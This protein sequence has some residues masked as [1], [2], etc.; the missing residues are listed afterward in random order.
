[1]ALA[2]LAV[3][4]T[5]KS[6]S[7]ARPVALG[8][9]GAIAVA[10]A[11]AG[12]VGMESDGR[13]R[14]A[15]YLATAYLVVLVA[16]LGVL[17]R[18]VPDA[19]FILFIAYPQVWSLVG[20]RLP[21][22][23]WTLLVLA[24]SLGGL[25]LHQVQARESVVQVIGGQLTGVAFSLLIG[26]WINVLFDRSRVQARLIEQL[27]RAKAE[28]TTLERER[29][30]QAE[31]ERL[32]RD[33]HDTLAQG[34]TSILMLART[35]MA[36]LATDPAAARER[37]ELVEEVAGENLAQA[38]ALVAAQS[39]V[40]LDGTSLRDALAQLAARFTR[41]TGIEV[42]LSLTG[43]A[44]DGDPPADGGQ[45]GLRPAEELVLLRAAQEA[46]TN[47]RR[48][49]SPRRVSL[50]LATT[51]PGEVTMR[52]VDDGV[53]FAV[54]AATGSGLTGLRRRVE[55]AG[56]ELVVTSTPG[57]GTQVVARVVSGQ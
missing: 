29:G 42:D 27:E 30:A 26:L 8:A 37:L 13:S 41:E 4:T 11:V 6:E 25:I 56:G 55:E 39:P 44:Q 50:T 51:R 57:A 10:Y 9:I 32:A 43:P 48:H 45:L 38:R 20:R 34:Y 46:L 23:V 33:V 14:R 28:V 31:R 24:T 52:I 22:V 53:G 3:L 54:G 5:E 36:Q 15:S 47:A 7:W 2:A 1:M 18:A 16:G 40:E 49:A 19:L 21:G 12:R 35:A 17:A